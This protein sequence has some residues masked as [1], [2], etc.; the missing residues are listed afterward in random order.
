MK[1]IR[2]TIHASI[3]HDA[4]PGTKND[5]SDSGASNDN[6]KDVLPIAYKAKG[7]DAIKKLF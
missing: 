1:S 3:N 4:F 6:V 7:T 5:K 2:S